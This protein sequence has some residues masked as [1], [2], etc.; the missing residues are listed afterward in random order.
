MAEKT[1]VKVRKYRISHL[2]KEA[3]HS[4][5]GQGRAKSKRIEKLLRK[6]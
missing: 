1:N 3:W 6:V 2:C 4:R 5:A